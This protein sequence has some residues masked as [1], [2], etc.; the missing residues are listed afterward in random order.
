MIKHALP[1]LCLLLAA[2]AAAQDPASETQRLL[3]DFSEGGQGWR[4]VNDDVM[5]GRS[6][7]GFVVQDGVLVFTGSTNTRGGGFSSIRTLERE[8]SL[9]A[10]EGLV[11]RV[12][13]EAPDRTF[14][15]GVRTD[16]HLG[17]MRVNYRAPLELPTDGAWHEVRVPFASLRAQARGEPVDAP[18][19][20]PERIQT[21]G[22]M[23]NDGQDGAFRLDVDWIKA[24]GAGD[25]G[26]GDP[27]APFASPAVARDAF[28]LAWG[29]APG[30]P[31][32]LAT[33]TRRASRSRLEAHGY[34]FHLARLEAAEE[35]QQRLIADDVYDALLHHGGLPEGIAKVPL[36]AEERARFRA[37]FL[38]RPA[39]RAIARSD[40]RDLPVRVG[41][42]RSA[43]DAVACYRL[44]GGALRAS[45][46]P[47]ARAALAGLVRR[48][49][50]DEALGDAQLDALL[51]ELYG[52]PAPQAQ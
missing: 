24:Y 46:A 9:G 30:R 21:L 27:V 34:L 52:A 8:W 32:R 14:Q 42:L 7:G 3:F 12:R 43:G 1:W 40:F 44:V 37:R 28:A 22:F 4:T 2:P 17:R 25:L 11:V 6:R 50:A 49:A 51:A 35:G 48:A 16:A 23:L 26:E 18:A 41:I 5:G 36:P 13:A 20:A 33:W 47:E 39:L 29:E 10:A 38:E 31:E 45:S 19:L 15:L